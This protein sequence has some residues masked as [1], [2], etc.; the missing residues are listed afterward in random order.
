MKHL[1]KFNETV[2]SELDHEYIKNCF[3]E[4]IDKGVYIE[5]EFSDGYEAGD[6]IENTYDEIID[7]KS[8]IKMYISGPELKD[9]TIESYVSQSKELVE[10]YLDIENSINKVRLKYP[11][12]DYEFNR[13]NDDDDKF[14]IIFYILE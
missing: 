5:T 4:F 3:I 7:V 13:D 2:N 10:F 6:G 1:K 11:D 8:F 12:I 9:A 14:E